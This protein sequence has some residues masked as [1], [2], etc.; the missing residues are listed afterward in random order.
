[1]SLTVAGLAAALIHGP[2]SWLAPEVVLLVSLAF[3]GIPLL[4]MHSSRELMGTADQESLT[5]LV[6]AFYS[7]S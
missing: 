5:R 2:V 4:A 6:Q 1:M 7:L 3:I